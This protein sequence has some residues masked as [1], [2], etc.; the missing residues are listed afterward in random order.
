MKKFESK[1]VIEYSL[2]EISISIWYVWKFIFSQLS[3]LFVAATPSN[4]Y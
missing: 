1:I 3:A 4:Y 2:Y